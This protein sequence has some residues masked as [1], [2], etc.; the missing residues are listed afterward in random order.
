VVFFG[1]LQ[2]WKGLHTLSAAM[3]YVWEARPEV[4]L[5]VAGDG[6]A[7][8]D[9]PDDP[10]ADLRFGYIP[11][12]AV[13][14]LLAEASLGVLPYLQIA[15]S[16][17]GSLFVGSGV[18][19][20]V[21]SA[22]ALSDLV[23]SEDYVVPVGDARGLARGILAALDHD[24]AE[25]ERVLAHAQ[26]KLSWSTVARQYEDLFKGAASSRRMARLTRD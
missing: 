14:S 16:G 6:P 11:E 8:D 20:V 2:P 15:Q 18:P 23:P 4:R 19:V 1:K 22:G 5:V 21:T 7:R 12:A 24:V 10:R 17:V 25:R 9:A 13:P 26:A 3:R